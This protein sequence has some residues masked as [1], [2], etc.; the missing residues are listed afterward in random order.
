MELWSL[1]SVTVP[2]LYPWPRR[3][4]ERVVRPIERDGDQTVLDRFRARV[5]P[6]PAAT[7]QAG[8]RTTCRPSRSRCSPS[9]SA[10]ATAK[11]YDTHL[12]R[13]RQRILGP[14]RTS[15]ATGS[16]SSAP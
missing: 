12:A 11:I 10:P 13:E 9:S 14:S 3:F 8:R 1:L 6:V 4:A 2:G 15:T 16:P 7:H 5:K